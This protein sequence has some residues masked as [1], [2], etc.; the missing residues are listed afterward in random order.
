MARPNQ[1]SPEKAVLTN[2]AVPLKAA[3][4]NRASPEKVALSNE[5]LP[6]KM[7]PPKSVLS[8]SIAIDLTGRLPASS[9]FLS[10]PGASWPPSTPPS[11]PFKRK[12]HREKLA[13][14]FSVQARVSAF[15]ALQLQLDERSEPCA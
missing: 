9:F 6:G 12:R 8:L 5:A 2:E 10:S 15:L 7:K 13:S 4:S 11:T 14:A 3:L 1:A